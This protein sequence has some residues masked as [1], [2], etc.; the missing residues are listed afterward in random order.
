MNPKEKTIADWLPITQGQPLDGVVVDTKIDDE[1]GSRN[2]Q[3]LKRRGNLWFVEDGSMY[4]YYRP[5]HWRPTDQQARAER[6]RKRL[7]GMDRDRAAVE[8]ELRTCGVPAAPAPTEWMDEARAL[9]SEVYGFASTSPR[10]QDNINAVLELFDK[11]AAGVKE[12]ERG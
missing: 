1:K 11:H 6:L 9:L 5:T 12:D 4:V 7:E 2:E 3:P 10:A 8:A